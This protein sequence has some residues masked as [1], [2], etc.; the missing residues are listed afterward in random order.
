MPSWRFDRQAGRMDPSRSVA[1]ELTPYWQ[2]LAAAGRGVSDG[3][4]FQN[5]FNTEMATGGI[6][7]GQPP[8]EA[9]A[10]QRDI[11]YL[12]VI[13]YRIAEKLVEAGQY[14]DINGF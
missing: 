6:E 1:L 10:S 2:S 4:V 11:D 3:W 9:G 8:F 14:T 5:S 13:N 7:K 12:H